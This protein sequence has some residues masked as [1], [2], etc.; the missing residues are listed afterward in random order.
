MDVCDVTNV[1]RVLGGGNRLCV[2]VACMRTCCTVCLHLGHAHCHE[3]RALAP[4]Q[5]QG[6]VRDAG[7]TRRVWHF[8]DTMVATD[9]HTTTAVLLLLSR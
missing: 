7:K 3:A 2:A 6:C 5:F 8:D 4:Q 9:P 1:A